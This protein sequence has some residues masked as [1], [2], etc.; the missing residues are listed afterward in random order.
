MSSLH[1][2]STNKVAIQSVKVTFIS[3][4]RPTQH[5]YS[6]DQAGDDEDDACSALTTAASLHASYIHT[7]ALLVLL[8]ACTTVPSLSALHY[9]PHPS[10]AQPLLAFPSEPSRSL[11]T[12]G[13]ALINSVI[14]LF[15]CTAEFSGT[16]PQTTQDNS[17]RLR[18]PLSPGH[19]FQV[20]NRAG[21]A[22]LA[23]RLSQSRS[24]HSGRSPPITRILLS[25]L[26]LPCPSRL[27]ASPTLLHSQTLHTATRIICLAVLNNRI[28]HN[29]QSRPRFGF[30]VLHPSIRYVISCEAST[31]R[32]EGG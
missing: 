10:P 7:P 3:S 32:K 21:L 28:T 25:I 11:S 30:A 24:Q 31:R 18:G 13:L 8:H 22:D 29:H 20:I 19:S 23:D 26:A 9:L 16:T 17:D 5:T 12:R 14:A 15:N 27:T 6:T 1:V 2:V 4:C